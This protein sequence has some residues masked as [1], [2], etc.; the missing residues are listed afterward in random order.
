MYLF[1]MIVNNNP[2]NFVDHKLYILWKAWCFPNLRLKLTN[3]MVDLAI[4]LKQYGCLLLNVYSCPVRHM[5]ANAKLELYAL[6]FW[7]KLWSFCKFSVS[8]FLSFW[9]GSLIEES[10][11]APLEQQRPNVALLEGLSV[12]FSP[13]NINA[14]QS[15]QIYFIGPLSW[16]LT[17]DSSKVSKLRLPMKL[18]SLHWVPKSLDNSFCFAV[19]CFCLSAFFLLL[20]SNCSSV[21]LV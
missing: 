16:Y 18:I 15:Q 9:G 14:S 6:K 13:L 1:Q 20:S 19:V 4:I 11:I 17:L 12:W 7:W 8:K 21:W 3:P 5:E 2:A 10:L